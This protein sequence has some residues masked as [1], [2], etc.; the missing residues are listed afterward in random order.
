MGLL[1]GIRHPE[2]SDLRVAPSQR[3]DRLH[4]LRAWIRSP[5][6]QLAA[7]V[8]QYAV[9]LY[10]VATVAFFLPRLVPGNPIELL[11]GQNASLLPSSVI[12]ATLDHVGLGR[13]LIEQ[14]GLFLTHTV[15]GDLGYSYAW[16]QPVMQVLLQRLPWTLLLVGGALLLS[17]IIGVGVGALSAWRRG[18]RLDAGLVAVVLFVDSMPVF[19]IGMLLL[20]LFAVQLGW[21]PIFGATSLAPAGGL[22]LAAGIAQHLV[23][24]LLTLTLVSIGGTFLVTRAALLHTLRADYVLAAR[25]RGL[26]ESTILLRHALPNAALPI[27]TLLFLRVAFLLGGAVVVE[28][29]FSYPGLGQLIGQ[30]ALDHDYPVAQ[31][32]FLLLGV[33]I[34]VANL[35]ADLIYPRLDPRLRRLNR[36]LRGYA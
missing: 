14:Y 9:V 17:G 5:A 31:G 25:A 33:A 4:A 24:P 26:R 3:S 32:A 29:L 12:Q 34:V 1:P 16:R 20:Q 15:R 35:G 11:L 36:P 18:A 23:L 13:P 6:A 8:A 19:W 28:T 27:A 7:R 21:L 30:S 22:T 10:L 2:Q